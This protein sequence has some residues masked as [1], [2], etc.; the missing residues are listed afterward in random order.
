MT[1]QRCQGCKRRS[2]EFQS[3]SN[4]TPTLLTHFLSVTRFDIS[5]NSTIFRSQPASDV[6]AMGKK[7]FVGE[8]RPPPHPHTYIYMHRLPHTSF[9]PNQPLP[10]KSM[11]PGLC[12][13]RRTLSYKQS[14]C[15]ASWLFAH[16]GPFRDIIKTFQILII[17]C[18]NE[19][20]FLKYT[21]LLQVSHRL[22]CKS[23]NHT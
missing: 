1:T 21:L 9:H 20:R 14:S 15:C 17:L 22:I 11:S 10:A 19:K 3:T 2:T 16:S 6:D 12:A 5:E 4:L 18:L 23:G 7:R 8:F 13:H